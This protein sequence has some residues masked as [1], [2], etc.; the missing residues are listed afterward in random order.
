M[1]NNLKTVLT[2]MGDNYKEII[3][4]GSRHYLEVSI[5]RKA[6]E[7]GLRDI[8]E[9]YRDAHAIIPLKRPLAGMK[10]RIDG[11][12]FT[13]YALFASGIVVPPYVARR[14]GLK[15]QVYSPLDSMICNFA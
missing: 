4:S 15:Y 14:A 10:V 11:R 6:A 1:S 7:M 13:N 5:A 8:V 2:Q 3:K 12:T 9:Q